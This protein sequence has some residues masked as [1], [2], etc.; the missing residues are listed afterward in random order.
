MAIGDVYELVLVGAILGQQVVNVHHVRAEAGGDLA[1]DMATNWATDCKAAYVALFPTNYSLTMIK[2]R[3]IY[4]SGPAGVEYTTGLPT[5]GT[6]SNGPSGFNTAEVIKWTTAYVGRSRRGRTFIGP[7]SKSDVDNGSVVAGAITRLNAYVTA[8]LGSIGQG[9]T[10][11]ADM[12]LVIFS[13]KIATGTVP[14]PTTAIGAAGSVSAYVT[15]GAP[16][17]LARSQRRRDIG[18]GT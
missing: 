11:A 12:R 17:T 15:A 14:T 1:P 4:P 2:V 5:A 10:H 9:G 18:I 8:L 6:Q 13:H 7:V 3:Q 16:Q